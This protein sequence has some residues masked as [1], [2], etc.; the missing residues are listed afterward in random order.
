[1][2]TPDATNDLV[3]EPEPP[4]KWSRRR[5]LKNTAR[6]AVLGGL[7][8]PFIEASWLQVREVTVTIPRLPSGFRGLRVAHLA[9]FHHGPY[10]RL[11]YIRR[12]VEYT[13]GFA[14]DLIALVGDY[15]QADGKYIEPCF[16]V[17]RD[18][19]APIGVYAVLEGV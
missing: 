10:T 4:S 14:P 2:A 5:F 7:A 9:D 1:M 12:A 19:A 13:Q 17:L 11:G 3:Q 6:A 16:G 8:Y 15:V 18:L